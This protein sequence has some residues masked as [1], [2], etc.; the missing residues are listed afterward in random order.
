[1]ERAYQ[2]LKTE[3]YI[4]QFNEIYTRFPKSIELDNA[5][6]WA[7]ERY[8]RGFENLSQTFYHWITDELASPDYP[9]VKI[10]FRLNE[11][12]SKVVLL[13]IEQL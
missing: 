1:M 2:V 8:P 12:Q 5:I 9:V 10:V 7:L 4:Q 3:E 13:S 11:N 6:I